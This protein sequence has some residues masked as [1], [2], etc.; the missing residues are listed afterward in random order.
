MIWCSDEYKQKNPQKVA[1][2]KEALKR[3]FETDNLCQV[4]F[5][6]AGIS[7]SIYKP[8]RD[9]LSPQ[10]QCTDRIVG[11]KY[12]YDKVMQSVK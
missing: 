6:I 9:V 5:D 1:N 12:D 2:I 8:L 4:M 10:Y 3:P 11:K 7:T